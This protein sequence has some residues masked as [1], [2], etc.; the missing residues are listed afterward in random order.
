MLDGTMEGGRVRTVLGLLE[1][2]PG[3]PD[4]DRLRVML[5]PE[6]IVPVAPDEGVPVQRL[7]TAF[8]GDHTLTT[9]GMGGVQLEL[10]LAML[11]AVPETL[12]LRVAGACMAYPEHQE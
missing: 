8:R 12:H 7:A 9:V 3:A 10:R 5:R 2:Q 1:A 4:A 11:D 6:Q